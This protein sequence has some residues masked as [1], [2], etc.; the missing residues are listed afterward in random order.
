M[1]QQ[2]E[3]W[4]FAQLKAG[5]AGDP[6]FVR[7][8]RLLG[9]RTPE[10]FLAAVGLWTL[11]V[12]YAWLNDRADV[13]EILEGEPADIVDALVEVGL[14]TDDRQLRGFAKWTARVRATRSGNRERQANARSRAVTQRHNKSQAVTSREVEVEVEVKKEHDVRPQSSQR[15]QPVARDP[16]GRAVTLT[17]ADLAE[18]ATFGDEWAGFKRAWLA[19]GFA[20]P[21]SGGPEADET[22]QRGL[23]WQ[24]LDARPADLATWVREAPPKASAR[25]VVQYALDRWHDVRAAIEEADDRDVAPTRAEATESLGAIMA[26]MQGGGPRGTTTQDPA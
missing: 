11:C 22:S 14:I 21:P 25:A 6:E 16:S 2:R 1:P 12:G 9:R 5:F 7:L 19:R 20:H 17:K 24:I 23:L 8:A 13:S 4:D 10:S 18:W 3:G 26:R 15:R